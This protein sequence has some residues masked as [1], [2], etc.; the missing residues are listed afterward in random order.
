MHLSSRWGKPSYEIRALPA[1]E[2]IRQKTF[3][4]T[5][6][7]GMDDDLNSMLL[8]QTISQR[9]SKAPI[10]SRSVKEMATNQCAYKPFIIEPVEHIRSQFD[11]MAS[12][13]GN[14]NG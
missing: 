13:I 10:D 3:W 4:E 5:H 2:F 8:S 6:S 7:W 1:S 11:T 9:L 12:M 14:N